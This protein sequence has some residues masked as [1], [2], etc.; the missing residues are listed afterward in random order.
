MNDNPGKVAVV[1]GVG[2]G[3]GKVLCKRLLA[4]GYAVAGL[5]RTATTHQKLGDYYL[6]IACDLTD[7]T[8]VNSAITTIEQHFGAVSV[9]IHNAAYLLRKDFMQT[10]AQDFT[11][12][13]NLVCLGAVHGVQRVLPNMLTAKNGAILLTGATASVKAGAGFAAFSSAKFA[14][15]GLAQALA[16]GYAPQ[17]IHVAH[18]IIDGAIWGKQAEG[19]GR[20]ARQ[21]LDA[22]AIAATYLNLIHQT[23]SAWTFELDLRPDVEPF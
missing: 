16:R 6:P 23:R 11:A 8:A 22:N 14:L 20:T 9:Y 3:L 7:E 13:W 19:F 1:A 4:A 12:L 5:S 10:T 18:I 17:G 2:D 15:R 21:C